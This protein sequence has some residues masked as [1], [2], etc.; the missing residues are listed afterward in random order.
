MYSLQG[1]GRGR[2]RRTV[3]EG[4]D[5][6]LKESAVD[7]AKRSTADK[8]QQQQTPTSVDVAKKVENTTNDPNNGF[9]P[10]DELGDDFPTSGLMQSDLLPGFDGQN[11]DDYLD[12]SYMSTITGQHDFDPNFYFGSNCESFDAT[13]IDSL[14]GKKVRPWSMTSH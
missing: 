12:S 5:F 8:A 9:L 10:I 4:K 14:S 13:P 7:P 11:I 3:A 2:R 6:G 1:K